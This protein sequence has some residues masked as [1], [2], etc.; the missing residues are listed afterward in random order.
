MAWILP[1]PLFVPYSSMEAIASMSSAHRYIKPLYFWKVATFLDLC[2]R[3]PYPPLPASHTLSGGET[4]GLPRALIG[5]GERNVTT[6][7]PPLV[8]RGPNLFA[9]FFFFSAGRHLP[10][11]RHGDFQRARASSRLFLS[12]QCRS[13]APIN[14]IAEA[15][16]DSR[17]S[18]FRGE[19][20]V[21]RKKQWL[22]NIGRKYFAPTRRTSLC[23][24]NYR[25]VRNIGRDFFQKISLKSHPSTYIPAL[26]INKVIVWQQGVSHVFWASAS[27]S[28]PW[29]DASADA[30]FLFLF[31]SCS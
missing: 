11:C 28:P 8:E 7:S 6:T 14:V 17:C 23:E 22:H 12:S 16:K 25:I 1:Q 4:T 18:T 26:G 13:A 15:K 3:F 29:A 19:K 20:D 30:I 27:T 9:F 2:R 31:I 21:Q 10:P 5:C 24:V